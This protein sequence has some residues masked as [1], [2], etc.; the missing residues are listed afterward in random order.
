[1]YCHACGTKNSSSQLKC[2]SCGEKLI[3]TRTGSTACQG[4]DS[5]KAAA[6]SR[7]KAGGSQPSGDKRKPA[8]KGSP[9]TWLIPLM[10]LLTT[11]MVLVVYYVYEDNVNQEVHQLQMQ[12]QKLA[13]EGK[14]QESI[15]L[16]D[17]A[18]AKRPN[19]KGL[20]L[21]REIAAEAADFEKQLNQ[22]L[23][24]IKTKKI[25]EAEK[26]LEKL[27]KKLKSRTEP[28]FKPLKQDLSNSQVTL[29]V[30]KVKDELDQL[31]TVPA[32]TEKLESIS[33][34][35]GKEAAEL[36]KQIISKIVEISLS[37][38]TEKLKSNDFSGAM[39]AVEG[40][41]AYAGE[42][43]RL[44][45]QKE[46]VAREQKAFE[47]AEAKRIQIARQKAAEEDLRNR[48]AAVEVV[49][50]SVVLDDYGDLRIKG[51]VKNVA[52]KPI[53]SVQ[54]DLSTYTLDGALLG[55]GTINVSPYTL[56]QG[57]YGEFRA[58]LYGA[59]TE[60]KAVIDNITWY[61]E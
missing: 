45:E 34:L 6:G 37:D 1:M 40:G 43:K 3:H 57:Q 9:F 60:G 48:T 35:E 51:Q 59:Y 28:L 16:L 19:H 41:L 29:S 33:K 46:R 27:N 56:E 14:Y 17:M 15:R 2:S 36:K 61:L 7:E 25:S 12:A 30:M 23:S 5:S 22:A 24:N 38:S 10:L 13:L 47:Q 18:I 20:L 31:S 39:L 54:L 53:S 21:D 11:V 55:S 49:N 4:V 58:V 44:L 50:M 52:T 32:L 8:R 42:D 26:I